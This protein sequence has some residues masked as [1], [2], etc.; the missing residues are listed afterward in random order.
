MCKLAIILAQWMTV[1]RRLLSSLYCVSL[2]FHPLSNFPFCFSVY[3]LTV[4]WDTTL[5]AWQTTWVRRTF[6]NQTSCYLSANSSWSLSYQV[7]AVFQLM[8]DSLLL[9]RLSGCISVS[10][11][12]FENCIIK[13]FSI[14]VKLGCWKE[15]IEGHNTEDY[16]YK[17]DTKLLCWM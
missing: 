15:R 10:L 2:R 17:F 6:R 8:N 7:G 13:V 12:A 1:K 11:T 5:G 9:A 16:L 14:T 3:Q 4:G